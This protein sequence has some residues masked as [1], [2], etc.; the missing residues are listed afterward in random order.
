[1]PTPGTGEQDDKSGTPPLDDKSGKG[2]SGITQEAMQAA[3]D[4]VVRRERTAA[5]TRARELETKLA[6]LTTQLTEATKGKGKP[7]ESLEVPAEYVESIRKPLL[8][9]LEQT[10][11]ELTTRDNAAKRSELKR[12]AS[13]LAVDGAAEDVAEALLP[14]VKIV[15][16]G[17][18]VVD[19]DGRPEYGANGAKSLNELVMEH[20]KSKPFL[21]KP[22]VRSGAGF[23]NAPRNNASSATDIAALKQ[24]I[25]THEAKHEFG[26]A[27][28]LKQ[29]L[30]ELQRK[31]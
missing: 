8:E 12:I 4:A 2:G 14:K 23:G 17:Y 30:L 13:E 3:I 5:D 1:M 11:G 19:K 20:L 10:R 27:A 9:Q 15:A 6:D 31:K 24:Q 29:Q 26:A 18:E 21:A 22:G 7:N 25:A 28:P 16:N